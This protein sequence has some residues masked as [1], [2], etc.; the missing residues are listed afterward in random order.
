MDAAHIKPRGDKLIVKREAEEQKTQSGIILGNQ[1]ES[2]SM[3]AE[4][5]AVSEQIKGI[6]V[7]DKI[8]IDKRANVKFADF[9]VI[10]ENDVFAV[11]KE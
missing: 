5:L 11:I 3:I 7:G 10:K 8:L 9:W 4:V 1:K 6:T 2:E